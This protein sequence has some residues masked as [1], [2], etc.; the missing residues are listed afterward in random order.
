MNRRIAIIIDDINQAKQKGLYAQFKDFLR[1]K[2][3]RKQN[4][5]IF[6]IDNGDAFVLEFEKQEAKYSL[7]KQ[8]IQLLTNGYVRS[9]QAVNFPE[10]NIFY[11]MKDYERIINLLNDLLELQNDERGVIRLVVEEPVKP[12]VHFKVQIKEKIKIFERFVKIGW[13]TYKRRFD[14]LTG[15]DYIVVDGTTLY[16]RYDKYGREYL[17]V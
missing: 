3:C 1:K 2:L 14:F 9:P 5:P 12:V 13:N 16:V 6:F 8:F 17:D 10:E 15:L 11:L 7:E 4:T